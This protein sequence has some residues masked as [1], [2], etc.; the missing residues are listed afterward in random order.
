VANI[1]WAVDQM[2]KGEKVARPG[3]NGKGMW[4]MIYEPKEGEEKMTLPYVFIKT[5]KDEKVPWL[6]SQ[7]DLLA[8]DWDYA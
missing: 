4:I 6:A 5:G 1:G 8:N 3:W 2:R 7:V